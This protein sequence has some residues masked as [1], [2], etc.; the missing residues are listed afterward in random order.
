MPALRIVEQLDVIKYIL[1][2]VLP[3]F[4]DFSSDVLGLERGE[5]ALGDGV[6]ITITTSANAGFQIAIFQ[7][8]TPLPAFK[9]CP[10][11]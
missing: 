7:E 8:V 1:T 3:C 6:V 4:V 10:L 5:E 11:I 2:G 9:L